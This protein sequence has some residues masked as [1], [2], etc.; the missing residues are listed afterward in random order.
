EL[1]RQIRDT[2][3]Q[4]DTNGQRILDCKKIIGDQTE[5]TRELP[6]ITE[7]I[8]G[9]ETAEGGAQSEEMRKGDEAKSLRA[10]EAKVVESL[11]TSYQ[12]TASDLGVVALNQPVNIAGCEIFHVQVQSGGSS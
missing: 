12:R 6:D 10:R 5:A 9:F 8:R 1:E 3:S 2:T 4:L 7:K 11:S